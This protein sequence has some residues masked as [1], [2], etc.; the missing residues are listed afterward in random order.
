MQNRIFLFT[1]ILL[2][3]IFA[4]SSSCLNSLKA[5]Q[6]ITVNTKK[7]LIDH[8]SS[9]VFGFTLDWYLFQKGHFRSG[10]IRPE[11]L[12]YLKPFQGAMY[13]YSGGNQ[14]PW[15]NSVGP[16]A[17]RKNITTNFDGPKYPFFGPGEFLKF[18]EEVDG[19][20]VVLL[21]I[22]RKNEPNLKSDEIINENIEYINWL[23]VN[24]SKCVSGSLC[25][26]QYFELGNEI[27]WES[28]LK[29][30]AD[31]YYTRISP[32][33]DQAKKAYPK[34]QFAVSGATAPWDANQNSGTIFNQTLASLGMEKI[35]AVTFHPY[36]D[37]YPITAMN[38]LGDKQL[39]AFQ[40]F[41]KD[42]KL[43]VTEHARWPSIPP[44]GKWEDNWYLASGSSGAISSADY[45]LSLINNKTIAGAMWH[46]IATESPW[47]LFHLNKSNDVIYPSAVYWSL[48]VI[49]D[50]FLDR[51][52][53]VKP[54]LIKGDSYVGGY[55]IRFVAMNSKDGNVSL[56]GVNRGA[57][58]KIKLRFDD[59]GS[60]DKLY[61]MSFTQ[62]DE[63]GNQNTDQ[64][65]SL[66]KI[67]SYSD[68][69]EIDGFIC[70]PSKSVFSISFKPNHRIN[71]QK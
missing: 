7:V 36:Y 66:F 20:G 62:A 61:K 8:A 58:R 49:R 12:D 33:L 44:I 63:R 26:I 47:Q 35:D 23:A 21:D 42:I 56:L 13:R 14:F 30:S 59:V 19:K 55:D 1:L 64:Q 4:F 28:G 15:K 48:R 50:G 3:P 27:D 16:I 32:I 34:I 70:L 9:T 22:A 71:D 46:S 25:R 68:S 52:V 65:P 67:Q 24:D 31:R 10:N 69:I 11:T 2:S 39:L 54:A 53:E 29:W 40:K 43:L 60:V 18:L 37:G 6:T 57:E 17:Y 38:E 41:R 51:S 45:V 5:E